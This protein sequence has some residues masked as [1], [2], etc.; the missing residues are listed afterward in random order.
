M[1][2]PA[3]RVGTFTKYVNMVAFCQYVDN[4][5][6]MQRTTSLRQESSIGREWGSAAPPPAIL[7]AGRILQIVA[8]ANGAPVK[9]TVLTKELAIPRSSTVNICAALLEIGL[10]NQGDHGYTLGARLG[11]LGQSYFESFSPVRN[12][13]EYCQSLTP[14]LSM[15]VQLGTLDDFDVVYLAKHVGAQPLSIES[16]VGG[17]LPA[18]CTALGKAML[19]SLEGPQF[20][21]LLSHRVEPFASFTEKSLVTLTALEEDVALCAARGWAIDDEETTPGIVCI[22]VPLSSA[23]DPAR[24]Y[25]VSGTLLKSSATPEQIEVAIGQLEALARAAAGR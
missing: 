14:S 4:M 18:N 21:R 9:A 13:T 24:R 10:L 11:D 25:A 16:R 8:S 3:L 20:D 15:T 19:A 1:H 23:V 17:R 2:R 12:F 5:A 22:A 6:V 7:R